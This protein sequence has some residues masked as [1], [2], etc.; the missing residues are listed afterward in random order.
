LCKNFTVQITPT[1]G[2]ER[3]GKLEKMKGGKD[4]VKKLE[5]WGKNTAGDRN[6]G[7]GYP[8]KKGGGEGAL[9]GGQRKVL[10]TV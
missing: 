5:A 4:L 2:T 10:A 8:D 3:K 7:W 6:K 9:Y 1:M